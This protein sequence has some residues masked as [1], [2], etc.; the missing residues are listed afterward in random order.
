MRRER[1]GMKKQ[2]SVLSY[3]TMLLAVSVSVDAQQPAKIPRI[4]YVRVVGTPSNVRADEPG[5]FQDVA[6]PAELVSFHISTRR[7]PEC[8]R[9]RSD[10]AIFLGSGV[11]QNLRGDRPIPPPHRPSPKGR[12]SKPTPNRRASPAG[13]RRCWARLGRL[14]WNRTIPSGESYVSRKTDG[15]AGGDLRAIAPVQN[16]T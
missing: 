6:Q 13:L 16:L 5:R 9:G 7:W 15:V 14:P 1:N 3:C 11:K 8:A 12:R 4:G 2:I 10:S